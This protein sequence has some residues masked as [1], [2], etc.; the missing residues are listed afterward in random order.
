MSRTALVLVGHGRYS[1]IWHDDAAIGFLVAGELAEAGLR[2]VLRSTFPGALDDVDPDDLALVVIKS[3]TGRADDDDATWAG[4]HERLAAL[5]AAV[6]VLALHQAAN[7]MGNPRWYIGQVGG[8]W[9]DDHSW[10]PP[11]AEATFRPVDDEHPITAGLAPFT[12]VDESYLDLVLEPG[13]RPLVV[14]DHEGAAHPVVWEG[15]GPARLVY[16]ALGHDP[17]SFDSPGHR[18]LLRREI[19]WLTTP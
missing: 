17:R 18:D 6:P 4:F 11:I 1:D 2:P 7:T 14:V 10:H 3:G 15:P 9:V 12:A 16:H 13:I 19:A 8:Q 5:F